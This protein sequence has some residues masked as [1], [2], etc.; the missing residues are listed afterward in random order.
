MPA[1]HRGGHSSHIASQHVYCT[2]TLMFQLSH[3][4]SRQPPTIPC[5][6]QAASNHPMFQ[7]GS[8][9]PSHVSARQP[10]TIPC[11]SQAASNH[12]M[13]Q[14]DSLK[15]CVPARQPPI[16]PWYSQTA[17][18]HPISYISRQPL[19]IQCSSQAA[20]NL[21]LLQTGS[22]QPSNVPAS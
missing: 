12:P 15:L 22:L 17:S 9:Q 14:P 20:S 11:S 10:P 6:S 21:P 3:V 16:I 1:V 18:N 19:F 4:S 5:F 13:F 7:P 2:N 8:L